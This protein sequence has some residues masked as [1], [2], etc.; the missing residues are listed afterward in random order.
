M[1]SKALYFGGKI[2]KSSFDLIVE[3]LDKKKLKV[4]ISP[5][6]VIE[7]SSRLKENPADFNMV[8]NAVKKLLLLNPEIFLSR[9][10]TSVIFHLCKLMENNLPLKEVFLLFRL[11]QM[12]QELEKWI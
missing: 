12:L 4:F 5:L 2:L 7:M 10:T 1:E 8:Q 11:L 9:A 3:Q 6:T